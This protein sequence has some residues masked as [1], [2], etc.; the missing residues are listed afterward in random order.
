ML[1]DRSSNQTVAGLKRDRIRKTSGEHRSSNQTVA[2]LKQVRTGTP[3][4]STESSNQT[5]AGLKRI[6]LYNSPLEPPTFKSDR[7]GIET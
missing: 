2:G 6:L 1:H 3:A 7:C 4:A 5:V